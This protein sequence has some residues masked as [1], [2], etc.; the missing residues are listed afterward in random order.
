MSDNTNTYYIYSDSAYAVNACN[1]W[2]RKWASNGWKRAKGKK[3]E[4]LD[5]I[6]QLYQILK[7]EFC[8][9]EIIKVSGHDGNIGNE[10][11]DALA[12]GNKLKEQ[13]LINN[14]HID[15]NKNI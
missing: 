9:I 2:I 14:Y 8:N 1:D 12:S 5:I 11:A 6:Q 7:T 4:N 3:I 15:I 13:F 10:I